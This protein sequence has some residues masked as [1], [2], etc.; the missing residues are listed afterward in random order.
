MLRASDADRERVADRLRHA[1]AEG[2]LLA[3]ELEERLGDVFSARTYGELD[4]VVADLPMGQAGQRRRPGVPTLIA[5]GLAMAIAIVVILALLA[6]VLFIV[7]GV[8]VAWMLWAAVGWW[9][10]GRRPHAGGPR[11]LCAPRGARPAA[12]SQ[13][14]RAYL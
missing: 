10:F 1:T 6:A 14:W 7:T 11:R 4:A 3:E 13:R 12:R 9:F 5:A 2:R 8:L